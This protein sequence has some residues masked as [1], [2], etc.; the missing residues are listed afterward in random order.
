MPIPAQPASDW[1]VAEIQGL[2]GPFTFPERLLQKIWLR[3]EFDSTRAA[4]EDGRPLQV[5]RSGRWNLLGGPDFRDARL[6]LG[7]RELAG[8]VELH[9]HAGDWATH[10]H[11]ADRLYDHV[12]LHVVL[13]P[14]APGELALRTDGT[15]IPTLVLLPLLLHDLEEY[16][17]EDA[18]ETL[19]SRTD[20]HATEEL[21]RRPVSEVRA[22]LQARAEER[23]RQKGHFARRRI[24]RLGWDEACHHAALEILG[25]RFNRVPMLKV[26]VR[27]PLADWAGGTVAVDAL[28]VA[29]RA[30][31]SR[32]GLR[33]ANHP[34]VRLGQYAV[35]THAQPTWPGQLLKLA[36]ALAILPPEGRAWPTALVRRRLDLPA[37]RARFAC[38]IAAE[39]IGGTRLDNLV[40]DGFLPLLSAWTSADYFPLWFHWFMG[41]LP[42]RLASVLKAL[43][44][45]DGSSQPACHGLAQGL[46]GWMLAREAESDVGHKKA[47]A[48]V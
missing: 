32:Q 18:V 3:G 4:T 46:L 27:A 7:G 10:A 25:Y 11:A 12:V 15:P 14:P 13:F 37:L 35:W 30:A 26:A 43:G 20:W 45:F 31:W 33:P 24:E 42:P 5:L 36:D 28:F 22:L 2:Y 29:E 41:D 40:C 21:A 16:A 1:K 23:W 47:P 19:A 48:L 38:E 39:A 9:L 34:R 17:A 8:D 6:C 44:I